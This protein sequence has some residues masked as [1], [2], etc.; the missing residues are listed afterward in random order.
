DLTSVIGKRPGEILGCVHSSEGEGGCGT[1]EACTYCGAVNAVLQSQKGKAA[2]EDCRLVLGSEE[3]S[4][5]LRIW[6]APLTLADEEF[7]AVT[8]QDIRH[9]KRRTILERIFFHDIL[10]TTQV[11]L[12]T[13]E[14]LRNYGDKVDQKEFLGKLNY[15]VNSLIDEIQSQ[16]IL[17][18]A[19]NKSLA[20]SCSTFNS[21]DFLNEMINLFT[22]HPVAEGKAVQINPNIDAINITSDQNLLKRIIGN[23]IKNAF[24]ATPR[25][26]IVTLGC[27]VDNGRVQFSVHNPSY[28][29]REVQLQIFQRSFS[30]KG[31]ARGLGTYSIK[32][33]S[34]FLKGNVTFST[35]KEDGT[36]FK[37]SY[38]I[39]L[40]TN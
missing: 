7:Y 26:G 11:L 36:T 31:P 40:E 12:S 39:D 23:L 22:N 30:T 27:E 16:R 14:I 4:Y 13:V 17:I 38:P 21:V 1:S 34:T 33:L 25:N 2:V 5:D 9:E 35:S 8:I 6:A 32:L 3:E 18:A 20:I 28:I 15:L 24:E 19:E 37:A 29:S 10:N